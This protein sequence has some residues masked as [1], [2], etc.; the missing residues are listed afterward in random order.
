MCGRGGGGGGSHQTNSA[1]SY[2]DSFPHAFPIPPCLPY[3]PMPYLS[4]HAPPMPYLSPHAPPCLTYPPMPPPMPS[5]SCLPYPPM[6]SLSCL[7]YPPMPSLSP[8]ALPIPPC[9]PPPHAF[10]IPPCLP[11]H[12]F[13]IPPCLPYPPMPY[14]SPHAPPPPPP[15]LTYHLPCRSSFA[16]VTHDQK[17]HYSI[18]RGPVGGGGL[19]KH[20]QDMQGG[21]CLVYSTNQEP[22]CTINTSFPRTESSMSTC[23]S[24]ERKSLPLNVSV[25]LPSLPCNAKCF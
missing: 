10:P 12:A 1:P 23:V 25:C 21:A 13:P 24:M 9:P 16:S 7:P 11:Y 17:L 4:P 18:V 6:P 5:L 15:C 14:L 2:F 19:N 20:E 8:Y 22:V 3:P